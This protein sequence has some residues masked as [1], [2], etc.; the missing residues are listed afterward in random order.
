M[1]V[2]YLLGVLVGV[3]GGDP[4]MEGHWSSECGPSEVAQLGATTEVAE[5]AAARVAPPNHR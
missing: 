1:A 4:E 2:G 5:A 3:K